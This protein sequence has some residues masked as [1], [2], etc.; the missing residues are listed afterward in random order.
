[1]GGR[2]LS[3]WGV[4]GLLFLQSIGAPNAPPPWDLAIVHASILAVRTG[5]VL[6]AEYGSIEDGK[7]ADLILFDANPLTNP[8][9]LLGTKTVIKDG[10]VWSP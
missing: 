1:M 5:E 6:D 8:R 7:R 10:V 3:N 4:V 9:D 2:P